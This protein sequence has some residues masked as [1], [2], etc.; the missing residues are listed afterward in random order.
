VQETSS[1]ISMLKDTFGTDSIKNVGTSKKIA[2]TGDTR[3]MNNPVF[4]GV[5]DGQAG[6]G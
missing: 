5:E 1:E 4:I 6:G 2:K 3:D